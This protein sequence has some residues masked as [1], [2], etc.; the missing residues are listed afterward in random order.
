MSFQNIW[1][2]ILIWHFHIEHVEG[3]SFQTIITIEIKAT[4][5][6][7]YAWKLTYMVCLYF[8]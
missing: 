3:R 1:A 8:S 4:Q 5:Q 6:A 7:R 2:I